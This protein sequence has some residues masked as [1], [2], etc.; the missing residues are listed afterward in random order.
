MEII[1]NFG[2]QKS[3]EAG[4]EMIASTGKSS[5]GD[6][7]GALPSNP[8]LAEAITEWSKN[9]QKNASNYGNFIGHWQAQ[10]QKFKIDWKISYTTLA[11]KSANLIKEFNTWL[12]SPEFRPIDQYIR[13]NL[14]A[15]EQNL[16]FIQTNNHQ[17]RQLPWHR[18][19]LLNDFDK[20]QLVF[21]GSN[22]QKNRPYSL[23][24][25]PQVLAILGYNYQ[26][27][28]LKQIQKAFSNKITTIE[29]SNSLE[30]NQ[31]ICQKTWDIIFYLGHSQTKENGTNS[32]I[33]IGSAIVEI[34]TMQEAFKKAIKKG[35]KLA[36]FWSC[37]G[38]GIAHQ[39]IQTQDYPLPEIVVMRDLLP[40][41]MA[42]VLLEKFLKYLKN[43]QLPSHFS[44][45]LAEELNEL[46]CNDTLIANRT[47]NYDNTFP[48]IDWLPVIFTN[49]IPTKFTL[50]SIP[51]PHGELFL[52]LVIALFI[53]VIRYCGVLQTPELHM[54]DHFMRSRPLEPPDPRLVLVEITN[55][56]GEYQEKRG[57]ANFNKNYSSLADGALTELLNK[58]NPYQPRVIG[59]D[60]YRTNPIKPETDNLIAICK[61][62]GEAENNYSESPPPGVS[63][64]N[65]S[66]SNI[67]DDFDRVTR[68]QILTGAGGPECPIIDS[69]SYKVF[70]RYVDTEAQPPEIKEDL[71]LIQVG[72]TRFH[73]LNEQNPG[74]YRLDT[75]DI[76]G[77]QMLINYRSTR[78]KIATTVTLQQILETTN[79]TELKKLIENKIILIGTSNPRYNDLHPTPLPHHQQDSP[80]NQSSNLMPGVEIHAHMISQM[81]SAV[82]D[83]RPLIWWLPEPLEWLW[84]LLW[85][86]FGCSLNFWL[87]TPSTLLWALLAAFIGLAIIC[88]F[89]FLFYCG[90]L[91]FV[92]A[93]SVLIF[94]TL[95]ILVY[96]HLFKKAL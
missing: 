19:K 58:I 70:S 29:P 37:D 41:P 78:D 60:I 61:S 86:F 65:L 31:K 95:I 38:L 85:A 17:L 57:F 14:Q 66:F 88:Y 62:L 3:I 96:R 83:H 15:H 75:R 26:P 20:T 94:T 47:T 84:I 35:L 10:N 87:K 36:V 40:T 23:S 4:F 7:N 93:F 82:F 13:N 43:H 6:C 30:L 24:K 27:E 28:C 53:I 68:R 18:W 22:P 25:N 44:R 9:Y 79:Q 11:K 16:I 32:E 45:Q 81:L 46:N 90:W 89:M 51:S 48:C 72:E 77:F 56:D 49:T 73:R 33:Q 21:C 55:S 71:S 52:S 50:P 59:L 91:P 64:D 2:F 5:L 1:L 42:P 63:E 69:F 34:K 54:Y 92:P 67:T 8:A 39:L 76:S 80:S 12:D 74:G